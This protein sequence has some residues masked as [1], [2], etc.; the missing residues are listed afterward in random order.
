MHTKKQLMGRTPAGENVDLYTLTNT[1]GL[2]AQIMTYG[3][4]LVSVET[5][6]R[7]GTIGNITLSLDSLEDYLRGHPC[8]GSTIGRFANRIAKG[9]FRID[10]HEYVL[11]VNNGLNH[12]H[13][14]VR[15]FDKV[16][17]KAE[18]VEEDRCA[19]IA[20]SYESPDGEEGYPGNLA[21]TVIYRLTDND[22]LSIEYSAT[23]DKRTVV[24]LTN[25]AYWNLANGGSSDVLGHEL[26]LDADKIL[27]VDAGLIPTGELIAV[28]STPYDFRKPKTVGSAMNQLGGGFDHCFILNKR[29]D[30]RTPTLAARVVEP[31]SGRM[32]EVHTTEPALQF[33]TANGLDGTL[34]AGGKSYQKH[35]GFCLE[36]Q[37]FPDSPNHSEFPAT[38]LD[39]GMKYHQLT[40]H[41]FGL[42]EY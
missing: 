35:N 9:R 40:V 33:Y 10:G 30:P 27:A 37:H 26:M 24:N 7:D 2:R 17:W 28:E 8:L 29:R 20:L 6:D 42:V 15:G 21:V 22:E 25:H 5:P 36:A 19:G 32:M 14:G 18:A 13:G 1:H 12:L 31:G 11:A 4:T 38:V 41:K 16:L 23:T 34:H 39:P 3:A